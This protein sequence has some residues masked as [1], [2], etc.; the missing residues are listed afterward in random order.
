MNL[1]VV[2]ERGGW[3][4]RE[5]R[6]WLVR[7]LRERSDAFKICYD[8]QRKGFFKGL[9]TFA[10]NGRAFEITVPT[11]VDFPIGPDEAEPPVWPPRQDGEGTV[12]DL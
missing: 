3:G 9:V 2:K 12:D 11:G 5:G 8:V 7:G 1:A 10:R 4:V 6:D